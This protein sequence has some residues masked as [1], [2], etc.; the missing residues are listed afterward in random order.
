MK[1]P[2]PEIDELGQ[3][4]DD[5]EVDLINFIP[6]PH[7][8][9]DSRSWALIRDDGSSNQYWQIDQGRVLFA[10]IIQ[11]WF[12][13]NRKQLG[14]AQELKKSK[15]S[16]EENNENGAMFDLPDNPEKEGKN[17]EHETPKKSILTVRLG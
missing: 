4:E 17:P 14:Y 2:A 7:D 3:E 8:T 13:V 6:I 15:K 12:S 1:Q 5:S 16:K 11:Q 9:N 10:S